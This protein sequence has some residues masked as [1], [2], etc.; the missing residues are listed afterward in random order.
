MHIYCVDARDQAHLSGWAS[1]TCWAFSSV[2]ICF[3]FI[4]SNWCFLSWLMKPSLLWLKKAQASFVNIIT[5]HTPSASEC[6]LCTGALVGWRMWVWYEETF[7]IHQSYVAVKYRVH[8]EKAIQTFNK[9]K[10]EIWC[11]SKKMKEGNPT[12]P[13]INL[14]AL[15]VVYGMKTLIAKL[16]GLGLFWELL[17]G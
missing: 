3:L 17:Q 9:P 6:K 10:H 8:M 12:W 2:H 15:A 1:S 14:E 4:I 7:Q 11:N 16:W 5:T 13:E